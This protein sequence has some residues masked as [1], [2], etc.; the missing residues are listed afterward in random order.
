MKKILMPDKKPVT[1]IEVKGI[2]EKTA[3]YLSIDPHSF[4]PF[5]L[6]QQC[7]SPRMI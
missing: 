3:L 2:E 4:G 6:K 1:F 5:G 7:N